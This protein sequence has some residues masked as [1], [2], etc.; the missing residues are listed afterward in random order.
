MCQ[1]LFEDLL[2]MVKRMVRLREV[3]E[4]A[5]RGITDADLGGGFIKQR[6]ARRR[7]GR[8]G[9]FAMIVG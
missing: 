1:S 5:E 9:G 8:S 2:T 7:K 4:R 3:I 6:I